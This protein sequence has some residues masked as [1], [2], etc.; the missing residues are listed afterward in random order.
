M[1]FRRILKWPEK[2]LR[3]I[4]EPGSLDDKEIIQDLLDT[5]RVVGG[6]GLSAPQIGFKKR[7]VV[8]N[9]SALDESKSGSEEEVLINP[10]INSGEKNTVFK[11]ACFSIDNAAFSIERFDKINFSYL[12]PDGEVKSKNASGYYAAC[13]QHEI[14][15]L[16]GILMLDRLT[17][18]K[19]NMF[20]KKQR[21]INLRLKRS[22][23]RDPDPDRPG[24]RKKKRK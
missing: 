17:P 12:S 4:S 23:T 15:H 6:Y 9:E 22:K 20:L 3:E 10:K 24:F 21:K 1:T 8:I 19:R 14:D 11:E 5:F 7:I 18:L 13:I 2:S 16:D